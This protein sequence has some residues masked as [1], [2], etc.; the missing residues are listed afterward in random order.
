MMSTNYYIKGC[1]KDEDM[2][3]K[4]HI[5]KIWGIGGGKIGFMWAMDP[6]SL[7]ERLNDEKFCNPNEDKGI[8]SERGEEFSLVAFMKEVIGACEVVKDNHIGKKFC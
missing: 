2:E 1:P 4:W 8:V 5:G 6:L 3:P 7:G